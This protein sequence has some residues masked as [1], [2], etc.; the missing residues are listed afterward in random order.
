M[1]NKVILEVVMKNEN[2]REG[3]IIYS[4]VADYENKDNAYILKYQD[5]GKVLNRIRFT[6]A[7]CILHRKGNDEI[8]I[9]L[10][11]ENSSYLEVN[12]EY[13][14]VRTAVNTKQLYCQPDFWQINYSF[15]S[16]NPPEDFISCSW[17]IK[18]RL[19]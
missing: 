2:M 3:Q 9:H 4:G 6:P 16:T 5:E 7:S 18:Q 14:W 17:K 11:L 19:S 15:G 10:T 8:R 12:T 1:E 13:G